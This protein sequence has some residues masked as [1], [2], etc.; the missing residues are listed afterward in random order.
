MLGTS[1]LGTILSTRVGDVLT[2]RLVGAGLPAPVAHGLT[3]AK[4]Y[5]AQGV[6]PVP[7]G[8]PAPVARAITTGSHLAFMDGFQTSM[9]VAAVVALAAAAAALLVRRG[10][11]AVEGTVAI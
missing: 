5:V 7:P 10:E 9:A 8:T 1:V 3:G 4:S 6:A 2:H 11:G